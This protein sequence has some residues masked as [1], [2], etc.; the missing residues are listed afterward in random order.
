MTNPFKEFI[1]K[2]RLYGFHKFVSFLRAEIIRVFFN[3]FKHSYSQCQ[4]DLILSHL[5]FDVSKGFYVDVG[6]YD[7]IRFS[8][9]RRFYHLGWSGINIEPNLVQ[10]QRF[11][12]FRKRDINLNIGVSEKYSKMYYYKMNPTTLSTFSQLKMKEYKGKGFVLEEKKIVQIMPLKMIFKKYLKQKQIHFITIDVEGFD[13]HVLNSN[14]WSRYRP[15]IVCLEIHFKETH[16]LEDQKRER[17]IIR[18]MM[19]KQYTFVG[20]T[21]LN[22]FFVDSEKIDQVHL[23]KYMTNKRVY[24]K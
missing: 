19:S 13:M 17:M 16:R 2:Y 12:K 6:A 20:K 7:P 24:E 3:I 15:I 5:L 14:D 1:Y 9:T 11:E 8:N 10:F 4:E 23:M 21:L 22:Y 18:Y